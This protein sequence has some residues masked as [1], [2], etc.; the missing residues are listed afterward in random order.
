MAWIYSDYI[1]STGSARLTRLRLHIQEVSDQLT[2]ATTSNGESYNPQVLESY[3]AKLET[4]EQRLASELGA[5]V[6]C[7]ATRRSD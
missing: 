6:F 7:V 4:K 2:A 3:L 1:S 5:G